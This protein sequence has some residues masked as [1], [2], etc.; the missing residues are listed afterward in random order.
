MDMLTMGSMSFVS[1]CEAKQSAIEIAMQ[2]TILSYGDL[3]HYTGSG[4]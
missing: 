2:Q 1:N 4:E 3:P